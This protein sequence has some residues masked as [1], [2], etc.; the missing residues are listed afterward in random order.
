MAKRP[1][2][3][4]PLPS[5]HADRLRALLRH[6]AF[7]DDPE[8]HRPVRLECRKHLAPHRR[9]QRIIAPRALGHEVQKRLVHRA[10][11]G[12]R[13]PGGHRLDALAPVRQQQAGAVIAQRL[14]P[15]AMPQRSGKRVQI[16]LEG[17]FVVGRKGMLAHPVHMGTVVRSRRNPASTNQDRHHP[18]GFVEQ[19]E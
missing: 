7:I 14:F 17:R 1:L 13:E 3:S 19:Q 2:S 16:R 11:S 8:A 15:A 4:G 6:A 18:I 10:G 9:E 12:R 5:R